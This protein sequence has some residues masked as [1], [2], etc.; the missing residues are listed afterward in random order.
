MMLVQTGFF[1]WH[2]VRTRIYEHDVVRSRADMH[3]RGALSFHPGSRSSPAELQIGVS[4]G[5]PAWCSPVL[6]EM[7]ATLKSTSDIQSSSSELKGAFP[8]NEREWRQVVTRRK[9]AE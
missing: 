2:C 6:S 7:P 8:T 1:A 5:R 3:G 9:E 4:S